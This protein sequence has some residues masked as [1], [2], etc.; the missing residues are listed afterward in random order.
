MA[1][2]MHWFFQRLY[3]LF[4]TAPESLKTKNERAITKRTSG[5]N[6]IYVSSI[7]TPKV[8]RLGQ[9]TDCLTGRI[10]SYWR[11]FFPS[12]DATAGIY[13]MLPFIHRHC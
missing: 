11:R 1:T 8:S 5:P 13:P 12:G 4:D 2:L 7:Q 10:A 9:S 3:S 6:V